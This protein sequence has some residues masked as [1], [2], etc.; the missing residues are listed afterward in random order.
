MATSGL[1]LGDHR[2]DPGAPTAEH[3]A[4]AAR[5]T[6]PRKR[7]LRSKLRKDLASALPRL[8][9]LSQQLAPALR[10]GVYSG[11]LYDDTAGRLFGL[12]YQEVAALAAE[13]NGLPIPFG[14]GV[15]AGRYEVG[16]EVRR[17]S[18]EQ[19]AQDVEEL[20]ERLG[21]RIL[22]VT[23]MVHIGGTMHR[24]VKGVQARRKAYDLLVD[25]AAFSGRILAKE[26]PGAQR[27]YRPKS[28]EGGQPVERNHLVA[29]RG[30]DID[31]LV[32]RPPTGVNEIQ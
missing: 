18:H 26:F 25:F 3:L 10:A 20:D 30:V 6:R 19:V 27:I 28:N 5:L 15:L 29:G 14:A 4:V 9:D 1:Q 12:V 16:N 31:R 22:V 2:L 17:R 21:P 8:A 13:E 7:R 24:L 11:V 23:N 32:L